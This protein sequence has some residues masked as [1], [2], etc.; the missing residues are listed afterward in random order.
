MFA[1]SNTLMNRRNIFYGD[2]NSSIIANYIYNRLIS[3]EWFTYTDVMKDFDVC[4]QEPEKISSSKYYNIIKKTFSIVFKA[5]R[6]K[7]GY[8]SIETDGNNRNKKFRYTGNTP[9]PLA[10]EQNIQFI[11]NLSTYYEFCQDSA[12]FFPVSWL[13][14]FFAGYSDLLEIKKK[15]SNK[16]QIMQSSIDR[17]LTNIGL[18]PK[19]YKAIKNRQTLAI[20]YKPFYNKEQH[21]VFHPHILKEYNGRW[22]LLGHAEGREPQL[23]FNIALDRITALSQCSDSENHPY[24]SAPQ[25][26]Y[27]HLYKNIVGVSHPLDAQPVELRLRAHSHYIYKLT[28]TKPIHPSQKVELAF[29]KHQDGE[30]GEFT[31]HVEVNKELIARILAAGAGLEIMEPKSAREEI[32]QAAKKLFQLYSE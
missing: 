7:E 14:E 15:K 5:V 23:G 8:G 6:E 9:S 27:S 19:L 29:G 10:E 11:N 16:E 26:Y 3:R 20:S 21:L 4:N 31:L 12:G 2:S 13:E 1:K 22:H 17:Q 25:G 30:Y 28:E 32:A 18:L 24:R